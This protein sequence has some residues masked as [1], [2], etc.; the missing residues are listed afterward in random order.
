[1]SAQVVGYATYGHS[2]YDDELWRWLNDNRRYIGPQD[3]MMYLL[4]DAFDYMSAWGW[5]LRAG[6]TI[7]ASGETGEWPEQAATDAFT[8]TYN[9]SARQLVAALDGL[10]H[11][12]MECQDA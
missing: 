5:L 12:Q 8:I 9:G 11:V 7:T 2:H 10:L 6:C 3:D 1:M 4:C